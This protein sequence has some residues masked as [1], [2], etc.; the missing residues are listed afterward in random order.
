MG[1]LYKDFTEAY[2]EELKSYV[3][4]TTDTTDRQEAVTYFEQF[5]DTDNKWLNE[6]GI[7]SNITNTKTFQQNLIDLNPTNE[8]V[9]DTIYANVNEIDTTTKTTLHDYTVDINQIKTYLTRCEEAFDAEQG[10]VSEKV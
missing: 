3:K 1:D 2:K 10:C 6:L 7:A 5:N 9:I 8:S 4:N